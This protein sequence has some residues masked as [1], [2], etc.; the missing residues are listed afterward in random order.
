MAEEPV[1]AT[2]RDSTSLWAGSSTSTTLLSSTVVVDENWLQKLLQLQSVLQQLQLEKI[3]MDF[4][5]GQIISIMDSKGVLLSLDAILSLLWPEW[6]P[7]QSKRKLQT[8]V[9]AAHLRRLIVFSPE[10]FELPSPVF[11]CLCKQ[12]Y[13]T[14][15][16]L[17]ENLLS[18]N[19]WSA[20]DAEDSGEQLKH[21]Q[22]CVFHEQTPS[23][24]FLT[25]KECLFQQG[26][27]DF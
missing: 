13:A 27:P 4:L 24:P 17:L 22:S 15:M 19:Y 10:C 21:F 1:H 14:W 26:K 12:S 16:V 23:N 8:R 2:A 25:K 5:A 20:I 11:G 6:V 18:S 7:N 3:R 9:A